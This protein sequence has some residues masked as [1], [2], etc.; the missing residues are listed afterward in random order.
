MMTAAL[1]PE[2]VT[3]SKANPYLGDPIQG[4]H[5]SEIMVQQTIRQKRKIL[6]A[7]VTIRIH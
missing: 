4:I 2:R 5:W 1:P 3:A 6:D 7:V